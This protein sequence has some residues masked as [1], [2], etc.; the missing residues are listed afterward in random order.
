MLAAGWDPNAAT[1]KDILDYCRE[2]LS[3]YKRIRR[4]EFA[5]LPKTISGKIRRVEL[6]RREEELYVQSQLSQ[7][8]YRDDELRDGAR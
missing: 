1:A 5:D 2:N 7:G 6:C 3:P 8:E 4:I